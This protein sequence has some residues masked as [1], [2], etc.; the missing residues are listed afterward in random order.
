MRAGRG[1]ASGA[2]AFVPFLLVLLLLGVLRLLAFGF[3]LLRLLL[4]LLPL[5]FLFL[6][7][8][9]LFMALLR[10]A[11]TRLR[12]ILAV[13][14]PRHLAVVF[15]ARLVSHFIAAIFCVAIF[16]AAIF[17]RRSAGFLRRHPGLV[18][19]CARFTSC[20]HIAAAEFAG[21]AGGCDGRTAMVF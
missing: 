9:L 17:A 1:L 21:A 20:N 15:V 8:L 11:L 12:I 18:I 6:P 2:A 3:L 5:L 7:R 19:G 16:I 10:P 13:L 14:R 4:L